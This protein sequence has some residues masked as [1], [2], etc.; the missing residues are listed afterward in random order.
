MADIANPVTQRPLA[1]K[2]VALLSTIRWYNILLTVFA[3]YL[4]AYTIMLHAKMPLF[5]LITD[6]KLHAIV[7]ASVFSISGGFIINNFYD[8]EKDLIN[9]PH[10]TI[11]TRIISKKT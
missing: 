8:Y 9:R 6:Y 4:S 11:F 5:Q 1:L 3:Q 10:L 2:L 7:L